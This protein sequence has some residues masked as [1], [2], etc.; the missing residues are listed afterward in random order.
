MAK[1]NICHLFATALVLIRSQRRKIKKKK[2][3]GSDRYLM[4]PYQAKKCRTKLTKFSEV[5]KILSDGKFCLT[6]ILS[7]NKILCFG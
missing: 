5:T 2:K 4:V 3:S 1:L 7:K 6:K